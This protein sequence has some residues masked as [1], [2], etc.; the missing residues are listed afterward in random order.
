[1]GGSSRALLV[2]I[3][4]A[5]GFLLFA[6]LGFKTSLWFVVA[7]IVGHG[8][9]DFVHHWFIENRGVPHWWPGFCLTFD[10]I[11]GVWLAVRLAVRLVRRTS[12]AF[13]SQAG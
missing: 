6:V 12:S 2:E 13:N 5:S 3:V 1:M 8:V 10:V 7:A 4:V 9:F 11:L